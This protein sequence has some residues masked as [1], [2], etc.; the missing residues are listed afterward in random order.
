M[1]AS[2]IDK[3]NEVVILKSK[4]IKK[5]GEMM[6]EI[7]SDLAGSMTGQKPSRKV[8]EQFI[9]KGGYAILE[10]FGKGTTIEEKELNA[11]KCHGIITKLAEKTNISRQTI[12][13]IRAWFPTSKSTGSPTGVWIKQKDFDE[14]KEACSKMKGIEKL[15]KVARERLDRSLV[16]D[17]QELRMRQVILGESI[18]DFQKALKQEVEEG[19]KRESVLEKILKEA[20]LETIEVQKNLHFAGV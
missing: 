16:I 13:R 17:L 11:W 14:L 1:Q 6:A 15:L 18:E 19:E 7:R 12:Y 20:W 2:R 9:E 3:P 8:L 5:R 4:Q 10:S